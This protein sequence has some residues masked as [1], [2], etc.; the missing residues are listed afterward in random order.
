MKIKHKGLRAFARTGSA[1]GITAA[2]ASK[3][4]V[5]LADLAAAT[6]PSELTGTGYRLHPL[7]GKLAGY[8]SIRI[9]GNWRLIFRFVQGE[10]VGVDLIDYH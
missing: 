6:K 2:Q 7:K 9:T 8:W 1:R 5:M 3:L 10:A 4:A